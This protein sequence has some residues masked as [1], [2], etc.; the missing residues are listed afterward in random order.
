MSDLG[1]MALLVLSLFLI[2]GLDR[3]AAIHHTYGG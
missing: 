2:L 3:H 1:I